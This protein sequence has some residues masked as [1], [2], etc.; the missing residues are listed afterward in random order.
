MDI[1]A[2]GKD[3]VYIFICLYFLEVFLMENGGNISSAVESDNSISNLNEQ[4]L[5][6]VFQS[7]LVKTL[8]YSLTYSNVKSG[9]VIPDNDI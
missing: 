8:S 4:I 6:S 7:K 5:M 3:Q 2:V 1:I 9:V